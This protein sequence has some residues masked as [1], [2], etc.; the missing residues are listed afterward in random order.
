MRHPVCLGLVAA[1]AVGAGAWAAEYQVEVKKARLTEEPRSLSRPVAEVRYGEAVTVI[2][3]QGDWWQVQP[4]GKSAG[5]ITRNALARGATLMQAGATGEAG[6]SD[7]EQAAA[8]RPLSPEAEAAY[9]QQ[10]GA[11]AQGY[12][13]VDRLDRDPVCEVSDDRI[14]AFAAEGQLQPGGGR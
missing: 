7:S 12:A 2:R 11:S 3:R 9:R 8:Y 5:W 10:S 14:R 4:E 6:V 13:A 1:A